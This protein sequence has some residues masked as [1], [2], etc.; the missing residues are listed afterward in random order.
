MKLQAALLLGVALVVPVNAGAASFRGKVAVRPVAVK[1]AEEAKDW[2]VRHGQQ[3][4]VGLPPVTP[5]VVV[6]VDGVRTGAVVPPAEA[7]VVKIQGFKARPSVVPVVVGQQFEVINGDGFP[8]TPVLGG[9][10]KKTLNPEEK[11]T[12]PLSKPGPLELR[13]KE[14]PSIKATALV[15]PNRFFAVV[16]PD[17]TFAI[18]DVPAGTYTVKVWVE[19]AFRL[20]RPGVN[21]PDKGNMWLEAAITA[22]GTMEG[23]VKE[24]ELKPVR[25]EGGRSAP[26][27]PPPPPPP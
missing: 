24:A 10:G 22:N 23:D 8:V 6:V 15:M 3:K 1:K 2:R 19:D 11:L 5:V 7:A 26:P 13:S 27:P 14:W 20:E 9:S 16:A 18:D 4:E 12:E 17:G 21:F 25:P